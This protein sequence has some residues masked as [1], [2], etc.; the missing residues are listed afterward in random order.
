MVDVSDVDCDLYDEVLIYGDLEKMAA[1]IYTI[2]YEL[3]C[4]VNS[5]VE[6]IYI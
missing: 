1:N 6:K 3:I 5:R 2:S 4:D